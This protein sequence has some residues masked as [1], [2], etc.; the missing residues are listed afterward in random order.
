MGDCGLYSRT[1]VKR[2]FRIAAPMAMLV[3][4]NL[5]DDVHRALAARYHPS[6]FNLRRAFARV[7]RGAP[8]SPLSIIGAQSLMSI[9]LESPVHL[10]ILGNVLVRN[11]ELHLAVANFVHA[12]QR[13][14]IAHIGRTG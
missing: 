6:P 3:V 13:G 2:V 14:P 7:I 10:A 8:V 1:G 12:T 11:V 5:P 9:G 4:R